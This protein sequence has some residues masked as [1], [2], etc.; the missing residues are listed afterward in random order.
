MILIVSCSSGDP[1]STPGHL[2]MDTGPVV[3]R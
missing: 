1:R 2:D 3:G